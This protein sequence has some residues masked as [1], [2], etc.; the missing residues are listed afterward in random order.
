MTLKP[1][2]TENETSLLD[3]FRISA[4]SEKTVHQAVWGGSFLCITP[5]IILNCIGGE[6]NISS[7]VKT[8][9]SPDGAYCFF[10]S[11]R[12]VGR[13][14][15]NVCFQLPLLITIVTNIRAFFLGLRGLRNSPHSVCLS[16]D[17]ESPIS[18]PRTRDESSREIFICSISCVASQ[19][20]CKLL[21]GD[22]WREALSL[23]GADRSNGF[24]YF[25]PRVPEC[26]GLL[27]G[28]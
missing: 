16:F 9:V 21:S 15:N 14:T 12:W 18:G 8:P 27:L 26:R 23:R 20:A 10:D 5:M 28:T 19:L 22:I 7:V 17:S 6:Y 4:W 1:S 2:S 3:Y 25:P 11:E 24:P 13:I